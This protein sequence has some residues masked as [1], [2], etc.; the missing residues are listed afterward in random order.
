[1]E[2][3]TSISDVG[4]GGKDLASYLV[5]QECS[6]ILCGALSVTAD[7]LIFPSGFSSVITGFAERARCEKVLAGD[8]GNEM[9]FDRLLCARP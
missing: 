8:G 9:L 2:H 1:M 3:S 5:R 4:A 6:A 7:S